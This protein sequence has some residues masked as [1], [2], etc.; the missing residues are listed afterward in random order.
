MTALVRIAAATIIISHVDR[1]PHYDT[2]VTSAKKTA[3]VGVIM[4]DCPL[5]I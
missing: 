1:M 2:N 4:T 3:S 5:D